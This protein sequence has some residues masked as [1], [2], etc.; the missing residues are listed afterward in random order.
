MDEQFKVRQFMTDVK[1]LDL[2]S[3]PTL[4]GE[5]HG[6]LCTKLITEEFTE[7]QVAVAHRDLTEI[8]HELADLLYVCYYMA[9]AYGFIM[10]PIF[11]EVH[12]A[13]MTKAGGPLSLEGKLLKP[14]DFEPADV[15]SIIVEQSK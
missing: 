11:S 4:P 10:E 9:N 15:A 7:L 2:P 5:L 1:H 12:R 14:P 8:A 6:I 3:K 13:N